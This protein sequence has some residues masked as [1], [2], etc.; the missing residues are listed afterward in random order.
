MEK[1]MFFRKG[2]AIFF[3]RVGQSFEKGVSDDG[4]LTS[5]SSIPLILANLRMVSI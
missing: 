3:V 2:G 4:H 1:L 5:I